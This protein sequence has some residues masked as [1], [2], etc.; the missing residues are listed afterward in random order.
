MKLTLDDNTEVEVMLIDFVKGQVDYCRPNDPV[1]K[2]ACVMYCTLADIDNT[3][4][5]TLKSELTTNISADVVP[6]IKTM[7]GR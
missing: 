4:K 7:R 2:G 6:T 3:T 1:Y 5:G